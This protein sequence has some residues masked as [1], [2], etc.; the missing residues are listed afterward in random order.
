MILF[1]IGLLVLFYS[2]EKKESLIRFSYLSLSLLLILFSF[3]I[4]IF[5]NFCE[6]EANKDC[7]FCNYMVNEGGQLYLIFD[8]M[9]FFIFSGMLFFLYYEL[10][11]YLF[12]K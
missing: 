11:K 9:P 8:L 3:H 4:T 7:C 6:V 2:T 12:K 10:K 5:S 1:V